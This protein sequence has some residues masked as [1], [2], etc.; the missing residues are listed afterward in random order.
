MPER[1]HTNMLP[2]RSALD[3]LSL[4]LNIRAA[5]EA[6]SHEFLRHDQLV[7]ATGNPGP[8]AVLAGGDVIL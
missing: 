8:G 2:P 7:V 5:S 4:V 3:D 1:A 6:I